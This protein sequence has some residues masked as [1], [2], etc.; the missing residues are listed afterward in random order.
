M[1]SVREQAR[2]VNRRVDCVLS[3]REAPGLL[4]AGATGPRI[5]RANMV[6]LKVSGHYFCL[7]NLSGYK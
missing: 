1:F 4:K 5:G 6:V 7:V 3:R 2:V